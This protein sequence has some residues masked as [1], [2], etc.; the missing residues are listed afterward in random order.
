[1]LAEDPCVT[2][3]QHWKP[4]HL[5]TGAFPPPLLL[6]EL[7]GHQARNKTEQKQGESNTQKPELEQRDQRMKITPLR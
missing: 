1:M 5:C 3:L 7:Q 2:V 4:E 6:T